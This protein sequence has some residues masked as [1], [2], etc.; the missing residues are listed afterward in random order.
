MAEELPVR[1]Y[2][3]VWV[4]NRKNPPKGDGKQTVSRTLAWVEYGQRKFMS[5]GKNAT[6]AYAKQAKA[7]KERE[8]NSPAQRQSLDPIAWDAFL[9]KYL[10]TV[11]EGHELPAR[12]RKAAEAKWEKSHNTMRSERASLRKFGELVMSLATRGDTWCHNITSADRTLFINKRM[13][14]VGSGESV[15]AD[16]RNLRTAFGVMEEWGHRAKGSSPS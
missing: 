16:L 4:V 14:Q 3:T 13:D 8:L 6:L 7:D 12:Q 5:L 1:K 2:V 9:K 11:Y 15:D 10:D